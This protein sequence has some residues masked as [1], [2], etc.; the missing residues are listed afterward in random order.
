[1]K[2]CKEN[3]PMGHGFGCH[4]PHQHRELLHT[5]PSTTQTTPN[6]SRLL[7]W[8]L[9]AILYKGNNTND[10]QYPEDP[11]SF[12][13]S[14]SRC[15]VRISAKT[16]TEVFRFPQSLQANPGTLSQ[17]EPQMLPSTPCSFHCSLITLSFDA[18]RVQSKLLTESLNKPLL[19]R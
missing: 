3:I 13:T 14:K 12:K 15:P 10:A 9:E 5:F 17:A 8:L 6:N 7:Q 19:T 18:V 16:P 4:T 1:M 11:T 2:Q